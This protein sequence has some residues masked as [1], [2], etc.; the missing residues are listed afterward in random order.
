MKKKNPV[1]V[2][3]IIAGLAAGTAIVCSILNKEEEQDADYT[4][5]TTDR[6]LRK[7]ASFYERCIKRAIDVSA[8]FVGI[9]ITAPVVAVSSLLIYREDP[10][11]II[12][13][14]KRVGINKSH[15]N[16]H[17][18]RSMKQ[19]TGDIPTHLLSKE[20]QDN[21]ILKIGH[22]IR[23]TSIDEIPQF[24]DI[25]RGR[26]SLIGPRPALWNQDDLI[27]ERDKYR[28]NDIKPGLTGWAQINGRDV[29]SIEQKAELDGYYYEQLR[30]SSWSGFKMDMKCFFG[31]IKS[32]LTSDG[33][34]EGGTGMMNEQENN[35][36]AMINIREI[37]KR[38]L[39]NTGIELT[40]LGFG[41][42]SIWG[43]RFISDEEAMALFERAYESGIRYFDTG[44]SYGLAE[45]R[46]GKILRESK[47][48]KR[49]DLIISSKFGTKLDAGKYIHDWTPEWMRES[50]KT[51][52]KRMGIDYLD[53]LMCHGPQIA[54]MTDEFLDAMRSL[55]EEGLTRAIG[56]NTFDTDVIEYVRDT[57][58]FDF[59]MLDYNIMRQDR[60]ELIAQ[61]HDVG[62]GVIAGAALAESL[63]S[64]RVFRIRKLK[65][66]WYLARAF[67]NHRDKLAQKNNFKFMN[68]V[69]GVTSTQLALKY[70]LD[71]PAVTTA[72][73]GTTTMS[74]LIEN[75]GAVKIIIPDDIKNKIRQQKR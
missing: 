74:H 69:E 70:V 55:K 62:I 43:K 27:A 71:N 22:V 53:M 60:E 68:K 25:L 47:I 40:E 21:M 11:N 72:V 37:E 20:E 13:K 9:V 10:G 8:A 31:T 12:F 58:C 36:T 66:I 19:N 7:E 63:Y 18:L 1:I 34:V 48:V 29:I 61:L 54:D 59:V 65:D 45:E 49:K 52:L 41:C 35:G 6:M 26:M 56:I 3:G 4:D 24:I 30:K 75:V 2:A 5:E 67:V 33:V 44:Y 14:Q 15:F 51:S 23:K 57:K 17:K 50:V 46:I 42:A 38:P 64:N 39:G 73:F 16:I 28:A 32:V